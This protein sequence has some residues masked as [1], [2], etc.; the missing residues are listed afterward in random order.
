MKEKREKR[1]VREDGLIDSLTF[2]RL[3]HRLT[4]TMR[5]IPAS[6]Y[7]VYQQMS[8]F[9]RGSTSLTF[10]DDTELF[11]LLSW[12]VDT[13]GVAFGGLNILERRQ[14]LRS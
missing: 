6:V 5:F 8:Q 12:P 9:P 14:C 7:P 2:F 3:E 11:S 10:S 13:H 1:E 4:P